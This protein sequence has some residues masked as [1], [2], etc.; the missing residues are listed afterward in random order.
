M[1]D[2]HERHT[3]LALLFFTWLLLYSAGNELL[4]LIVM[5]QMFCQITW[6]VWRWY[7]SSSRYL[8]RP[9][10]FFWLPSRKTSLR[11]WL[12]SIV[13]DNIRSVYMTYHHLV[14]DVGIGAFFYFIFLQVQVNE[15]G[16]GLILGN[17]ISIKRIL[18]LKLSIIMETLLWK[19]IP[20]STIFIFSS[21]ASIAVDFLLFFLLLHII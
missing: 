8:H 2:H 19:L 11:S 6:I 5:L 4:M 20:Y 1:S 21:Q 3:E 10:F 14:S 17:S 18:N 9:H 16:F 12:F 7:S 15:R 13:C